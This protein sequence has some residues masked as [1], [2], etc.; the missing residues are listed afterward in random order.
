[1]ILRLL[2]ISYMG[3]RC[4]IS[5]KNDFVLVK[6]LH[7]RQMVRVFVNDI[8]QTATEDTCKFI[9]MPFIHLNGD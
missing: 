7:G 3:A 9:T 4:E 6:V 8:E 2:G 1:M 5:V